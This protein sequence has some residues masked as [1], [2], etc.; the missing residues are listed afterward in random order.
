MKKTERLMRKFAKADQKSAERFWA[1][2]QPLPEHYEMSDRG[3]SV[4]AMVQEIDARNCST[5]KQ[6]LDAAR[7]F[8]SRHCNSTE[9]KVLALVIKN[10]K[11]RRE[12]IWELKMSLEQRQKSTSVA[13]AD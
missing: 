10:G 13:S 8:A 12:S 3:A 5:W 1:N 11:N 6:K 7:K 4:R 2:K 9:Q